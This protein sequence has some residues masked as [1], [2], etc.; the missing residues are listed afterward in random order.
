[1]N[2]PE[3]DARWK[4]AAEHLRSGDLAA[5]WTIVRPMFEDDETCEVTLDIVCAARMKRDDE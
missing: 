4:E 5:A 2:R 3:D 1:M